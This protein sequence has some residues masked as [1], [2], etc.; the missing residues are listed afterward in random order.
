MAGAA[1]WIGFFARCGIR[2]VALHP[3]HDQRTRKRPAAAVLDH[4]AEAV[5]RRGFADDAIVERL[6][7]SAEL[8]DDLDCA[9]GRRSFLVGGDQ[10]RDRSAE[11]A[12]RGRQQA[13]DRDH[14]RRD[15]GFHV[16]GAAAVQIAVALRR[17][18]GIGVPGLE[19]ARGHDIG[20]ARRSI[21]PDAR[22]PRRAQRL[23]T[24]FESIVSQRNPSGSSRARRMSWQPAS[25]GVGDLRAISSQ[26]RSSVGA[27]EWVVAGAMLRWFTAGDSGNRGRS[28]A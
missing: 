22:S 5:D 10:Q 18:E 16:G 14:E 2:D 9:V 19:R 25:S 8:V 28:R 27:A 24:P 20:V 11:S 6:A 12:V 3:A 13:L 1:M 15:R 23:V 17:N 21:R 4:V 26:A 7:R